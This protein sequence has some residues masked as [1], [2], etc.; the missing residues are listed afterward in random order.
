MRIT[1]EFNGTDFQPD[2]LPPK[3]IQEIASAAIHIRP[4]FPRSTDQVPPD[5]PKCSALFYEDV[6]RPTGYNDL[7]V[8]N[9]LQ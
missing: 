9:I 3:N 6:Q 5:P 8:D 2:S 1:T 7:P 4:A